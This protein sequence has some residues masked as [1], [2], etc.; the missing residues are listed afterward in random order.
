MPDERR[1]GQDREAVPEVRRA[2]RSCSATGTRS[3]V[4]GSHGGPSTSGETLTA[5]VEVAEAVGRAVVVDPAGDAGRAP[6]DGRCEVEDVLVG[7]ARASRPG[8]SG[9][10]HAPQAHTTRS[11]SN[12]RPS[13][14][15]PPRRRAALRPARARRRPPRPARRASSPRR[16]LRIPA[17]GSKSVKRTSSTAMLGKSS[18]ASTRSHGIPSSRRTASPAASP[19]SSRRASHATPEPTTRPGRS[20]ATAPTRAWPSVC[21][22]RRRRGS[23][24]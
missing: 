10:S 6:G 24:G 23:G 20:R 22:R 13:S 14:R 18:V 2:R 9:A 12:R 4:S 1:V 3:S 8:K 15:T 7:D 11:A 19:A 21:A 17:S 16:G 5:A